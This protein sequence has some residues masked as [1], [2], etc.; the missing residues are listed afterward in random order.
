[1][2][3]MSWN[4]V[5]KNIIEQHNHSWYEDIYLRNKGNEEKTALLFWGTQI[6]YRDF[7]NM[8]IKYAK[9]LKQYGINKGDEFVACLK[10]TPDYPVLVAAASLIGA[11]INLISS[12]FNLDYIAQIINNAS[13]EIVFVADWDLAVIAYSLHN[14]VKDIKIIILPVDRWT[15][16]ENPYAEITDRFY[17]FDKDAYKQAYSE[18]DNIE[19][20]DAFLQRGLEYVGEINGHGKLEDEIAITYTSG[21]TAKGIHKGVVQRNQTYI[22]MGRYHDPEVAGIPR[23]DKII[24]LTEVGPH[25]DTTLLTGVSDTLM[26]GGTVALDPIIDEQYFL[27]S[28]KINKPSL[29]VATRTFWLKAM[30]QT[31]ENA[32]MKNLTLPY[33]YVPSEGGEPLSAG[34]EKALNKWL[35]KVKAGTAITH[36]PFSVVKMSVGGGDSEHGSLFLTLFRGYKNILQKLRKINEPIGLGYYNFADIQV[37]RKDGSYCDAMEMGRLVANS[38]ISMRKYHNNPEATE[39]YFIKDA[40]DKT[41]GDMCCYGYIDK[42]NNVYVKGRIG[43]SD[44]EIKPFQIADVILE[45]SMNIMSCEVVVLNDELLGL[46]YIAHIEGQYNKNINLPKTLL[47]A[48]KRCMEKFGEQ[49]KNHLYFRVRSHEEGFPT[50]FTAKRNVLALKEEGLTSLCIIPSKHYS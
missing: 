22:V 29:V 49:L 18:F 41:W 8:V 3:K 20:V 47:A 25:A 2:K 40:Y 42:W 12:S 19:N 32:E 21:S 4:V 39:K 9:A 16:Q 17:R 5:E 6:T 48:E 24:T 43:E 28:L 26:Q 13:S 38:P 31:Y 23:M 35:K 37:L 27:Y 11:K 44:P 14:C 50:L 15:G 7:F 46:L 10:Q 34:E 1:M 36:T 33:M 30:K 45:D